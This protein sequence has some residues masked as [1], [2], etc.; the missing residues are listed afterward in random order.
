MRKG[1]TWR[2]GSLSLSAAHVP[3]PVGGLLPA[4]AFGPIG[5]CFRLLQ[6]FFLPPY[7]FFIL[8]YNIDEFD[9]VPHQCLNALKERLPDV[10]GMI[11][12]YPAECLENPAHW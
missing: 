2:A 11:P 9:F 7:P 5:G 12:I 4:L 10:C 1:T 3:T 6:L 8:L